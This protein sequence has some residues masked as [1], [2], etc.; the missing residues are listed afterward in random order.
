MWDDGGKAV[1]AIGE[2]HLIVDMPGSRR[3]TAE[4]IM[5]KVRA[6]TLRYP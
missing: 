3:E 6:G 4:E 2:R 5:N 1:A